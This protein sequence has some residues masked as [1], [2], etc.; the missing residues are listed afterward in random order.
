MQFSFF[1]FFPF[2]IVWINS[3]ENRPYWRP[4]IFSVVFPTLQNM[5]SSSILHSCACKS[6]LARSQALVS[7]AIS[8][9]QWTAI[10]PAS[11]PI[12]QLMFWAAVRWADPAWKKFY[13]L[14]CPRKRISYPYCS[15]SHVSFFFLPFPF[16]SQ[17]PFYSTALQTIVLPHFNL[18]TPPPA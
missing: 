8:A 12:P 1:F 17:F 10:F 4:G 15:A 6:H 3:E 18:S 13:L 2:Q 9:W 14:A 5:D 11:L 16:L 7:S